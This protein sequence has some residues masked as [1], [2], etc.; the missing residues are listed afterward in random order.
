[1]VKVHIHN[2]VLNGKWVCTSVDHCHTEP[3]ILDAN[4]AWHIL[5]V[6]KT[7]KLKDSICDCGWT[8]VDYYEHLDDAIFYWLREYNPAI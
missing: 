8:G 2:W 6:I 7:H 5:G 1:M 4:T 3:D